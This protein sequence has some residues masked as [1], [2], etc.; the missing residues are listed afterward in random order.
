[1]NK[2][3]FLIPLLFN[4][5]ILYTYDIIEEALYNFNLSIAVS[6]DLVTGKSF[7]ILN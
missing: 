7:N 5:V 4:G 3:K 6:W 1:M 2:E